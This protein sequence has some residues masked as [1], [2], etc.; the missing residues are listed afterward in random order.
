M[1]KPKVVASKRVYSGHL[2]I[3]QD[4]LERA[5][6]LQT[7]YTHFTFRSDAVVVLAQTRDGKYLL[8]REYRHPTGG[9]LLG[10]PGGKL[11]PGEDPIAG[12]QRELLEETGYTADHFKLVGV[13]YHMPANCNQ[14]VYFLSAQNARLAG[15]QKL[16]PFE[17]IRPELKTLEKLRAEIA[18]GAPLDSHLL[19]ALGF[20]HL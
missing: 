8:N 12:G 10:C 16:D 7:P 18:A 11:E 3:T 5:D 14:K 9:Y 17:Y 6:G 2:D 13:T 20:H 1:E 4:L 15:P 19:A